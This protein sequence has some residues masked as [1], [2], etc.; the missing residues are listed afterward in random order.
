[1]NEAILGIMLFFLQY[2]PTLLLCAAI[3]FWPTRLASCRV[4][5]H[6]RPSPEA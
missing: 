3:L 5:L 2:G 6:L 4:R 1:M